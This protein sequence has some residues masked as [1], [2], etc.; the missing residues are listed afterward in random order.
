[1]TKAL[2][3]EM[4]RRRQRKE[5]MCPTENAVRSHKV[6]VRRSEDQEATRHRNAVSADG[7]SPVSATGPGAPCGVHPR[8]GVRLERRSPRTFLLPTHPPSAP[9]NPSTKSR[10]A[11]YQRQHGSKRRK[12]CRVPWKKADI[13]EG[14]F[15]PS[16]IAGRTCGTRRQA[17]K[18][19]E[20]RRTNGKWTNF[21]EECMK[22]VWSGPSSSPIVGPEAQN[23][24]RSQ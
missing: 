11:G 23:S 19:R 4:W 24:R 21:A 2:M 14:D 22:P 16:T 10:Q 13:A 6:G 5:R 9:R 18:Q 20:L 3:C 17:D 15:P 7:L 1:M 12:E 8:E